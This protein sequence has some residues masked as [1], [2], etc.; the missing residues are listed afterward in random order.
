[1]GL[2][3]GLNGLPA[4]GIISST[5]LRPAPLRLVSIDRF[6]AKVGLDKLW[7]LL[8]MAGFMNHMIAEA[9]D[10]GMELSVPATSVE[11][12]KIFWF[13]R[14][15]PKIGAREIADGPA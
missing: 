2:F 13:E 5:M 7:R 4:G 11:A 9:P 1:M 6:Y 8:C 12:Y 3:N 10:G 14:I 15:R